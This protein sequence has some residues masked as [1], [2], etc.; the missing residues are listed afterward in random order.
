MK[1][2]FYVFKIVPEVF[3]IPL[4]DVLGTATETVEHVFFVIAKYN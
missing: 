2:L 4:F 3:L 1:A